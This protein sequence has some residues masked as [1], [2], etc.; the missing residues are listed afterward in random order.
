MSSKSPYVIRPYEQ[1]A[2][3]PAHH[4]GTTNYR[5]VG[6]RTNGARHMEI[7]LGVIERNEGAIPHAHPDLEQAVYV[8]EGEAIAGIDG[9]DEHVKAGDLLFYPPRVFHSIK[10]LSEKIRLLVIYGPPFEGDPEKIYFEGSA[11]GGP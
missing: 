10:V 4:T 9:V 3:S 7:T 6:P 2:Y 1:E 8:L 11:A 5:L